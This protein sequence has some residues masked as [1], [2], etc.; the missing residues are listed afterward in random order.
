MIGG[1]STEGIAAWSA[2]HAEKMGKELTTD[3]LASE[4]RQDALA[5]LNELKQVMAK[6][7]NG[8][9]GLPEFQQKVDEAIKQYPELGEP[10]A[11]LSASLAFENDK[12]TKLGRDYDPGEKTTIQGYASAGGQWGSAID[13]AMDSLRHEDSLD[14][15]RIQDLASKLDQAERLGSNLIS[16]LNDSDKSVIANIR[17]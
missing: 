7:A 2:E 14:M 11:I 6:A 15:I 4:R 3:M 9:D 10:L 17:A 8:C 16:I 5:A 12:Y 1:I 13:G